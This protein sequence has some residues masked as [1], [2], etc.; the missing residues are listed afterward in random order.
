VGRGGGAGNL[1]REREGGLGRGGGGGSKGRGKIGKGLRFGETSLSHSKWGKGPS[2][3]FVV[4]TRKSA[5]GGSL[6]QRRLGKQRL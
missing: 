2:G 1:K 4:N 6:W 3:E 5:K